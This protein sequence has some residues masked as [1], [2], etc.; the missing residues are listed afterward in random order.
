MAR[1]KQTGATISCGE[2]TKTG[3]SEASDDNQSLFSHKRE[4]DDMARMAR[5]KR[6]TK[7]KTCE[8]HHL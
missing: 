1:T 3:G 5:R 4:T 6:M 8:Q 7:P 2:A